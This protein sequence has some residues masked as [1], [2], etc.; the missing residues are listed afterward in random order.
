M[1]DASLAECR[2]RLRKGNF[3]CRFITPLMSVLTLVSLR[4]ITR[5]C[6][7]PAVAKMFDEVITYS[8]RAQRLLRLASLTK[9]RGHVHMTS[10][11][12]VDF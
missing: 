12:F 11:K 1:Q 5:R 4:F 2:Y 7:L 10:A 6:V 9:L 3:Y 8:M